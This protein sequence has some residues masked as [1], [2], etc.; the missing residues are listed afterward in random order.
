[1]GKAKKVKVSKGGPKIGL[2]D[3]IELEKTVKFKN[4]QKVRHRTD[5]DEEVSSY[6]FRIIL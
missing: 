4:R 6:I 1:M 5:E 3:Q 2:V